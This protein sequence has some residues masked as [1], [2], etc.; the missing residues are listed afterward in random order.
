MAERHQLLSSDLK[1]LLITGFCGGYT[2]FSAFAVENLA[3]FQSQQSFTAI[4]YI[5]ASILIGLLAVW[6]GMAM[7]R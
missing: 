6:G 5:A 3:L 2:T 4:L 1:L 7:G